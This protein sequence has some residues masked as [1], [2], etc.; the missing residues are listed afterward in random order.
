MCVVTFQHKKILL[1]YLQIVDFE[2][3]AFELGGNFCKVS[4]LEEVA[5]GVIL[6]EVSGVNVRL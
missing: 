1:D 6:V 2:Y 5:M 3:F 4:A